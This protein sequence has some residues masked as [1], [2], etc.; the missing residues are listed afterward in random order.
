MCVYFY[1]HVRVTF[2][3]NVNRCQIIVN[4]LR[5]NNLAGRYGIYVFRFSVLS[6]VHE[7]QTYAEF[8]FVE[9]F[10]K[11][12]HNIILLMALQQNSLNSIAKVTFRTNTFG[13]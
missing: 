2:V 6:R 9:G 1:L 11:V 4:V 13:H 3:F 5:M 8:V 12:P 10:W 7:F